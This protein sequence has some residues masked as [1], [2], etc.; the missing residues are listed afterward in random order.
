M[1]RN[2]LKIAWRNLFRRKLT[3]LLYVSGLGIALLCVMFMGIYIHDERSFDRF[4]PESDL[5]YRVNID[6]KMGPEE[7]LGGNTP[8]PV[9]KAL[10]DN[11][12]EVADY[13]RLYLNSPEFVSYLEGTENKI[14]KESRMFS[15]DSNFLDFFK[16][17]VLEGNPKTSLQH[18]YSV[19]LTK[20]T[21]KKYFGDQQA[22][23]KE[24]HF[25]EWGKPFLVTA[26][27][28]D[29]PSNSSLQFDL[30]IPNDA[31]PVVQRF[32][33]SWVWLQMN[34]FVKLGPESANPETVAKIEEKLPSMVKLLASAPFE[35]I[36]KPFD[37]FIANGGRW[38]FLLQP[39]EDIHL[40]SKGIYSN[41]IA[42]GNATTVHAF[43][44]TAFL[45]LLMACINCMNL[46]TAQALRRSKEVGVK[47]VLGSARQ[48]LIGQFLVESFLF[49][50]LAV[51][52]GLF[53]MVMLMP[54]FNQL[55][56]KSFELMD[57]MTPGH[58]LALC[59]LV[60]ISV[61]F[62]GLYPAFYQSGFRP[63]SILKRN[64]NPSSI[65]SEHTTRNGLVVF[66][67]MI[68]TALIIFSIVVFKQ[69]KYANEVNLGFDKEHILL[70]NQVE[71]A[72]VTQKTLTEELR[73]IPGIAN[74][75]LATGVPSKNAFGDF[76][77]PV[78]S[79]G[80]SDLLK[81]L[82]LASYM[83]DEQ[84]VATMGLE[85]LFGRDF[86][87]DFN[88]STS[89]ILNET[90]VRQIGWDPETVVG[91]YIRYPGNRNQT[92]EV[93]GVVKD[94]NIES[95]HTEIMPFALF[96]FSSKT[97]YP[98]QMYIS[99]RLNNENLFQTLKDIEEKWHTL[100]PGQPY[101]ASFL[102]EEIEAMYQADQKAGYTFWVFT[103]L[104]MMIG[105][106]GLFGLVMATVEQRVREIGIRKV[107]G[108]PVSSL[109]RVLS[110]DYIKLIFVAVL[111]ASPLAWWAMG[112]WLQQFAY[113]VDVHIGYFVM[114]FMLAIMFSFPTILFQTWK[115]AIS[116]PVESLKSE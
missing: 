45:I 9:G 16:F 116:N 8:P 73:Q 51:M 111:I 68:S 88:D 65:F 18:T 92:F 52:L 1:L 29:L 48:Q 20:S 113:Q 60:F 11:F 61:L 59:F 80:G 14:F 30:L 82:A 13:T 98:R 57:L 84:F 91:S 7:F 43:I 58:A 54:F 22:L 94:F 106:I 37:E 109:V 81:D 72:G 44:F 70:L 17:P 110:Q 105:C 64:V 50:V 5:I 2:Y 26:V 28:E 42:H 102:D 35:R 100:V 69:L 99:L 31:N 76:Y 97:Y 104:A 75:S 107:L 66:Q 21:A 36:G 67:F 6:G 33:W 3:S 24:L 15:V 87:L 27:L 114:A 79:E 89:I 23:G 47:K 12:P 46:T 93:I 95:L 90:A 40:G 53:L 74:A 115:A 85:I 62:S 103:L 101:Q 34:T 39:M 55:T 63:M 96:H 77:V 32:D 56:G 25:D 19:V 78:S 49:S 10:L 83:V 86:S 112:Y 41:Q 71:K 38:D 108:A 4:L